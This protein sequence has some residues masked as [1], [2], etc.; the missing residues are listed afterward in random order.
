MALSHLDRSGRARMVDVTDKP[1]TA[2]IATASGKIYM[3]A[4]TLKQIH[5]GSVT[6]GDVFSVAQ[7]AGILAAKR[8]PDLIPMCHP[9]PISGVELHFKENS[10][11]NTE[12]VVTISVTAT[13][14]TV[15]QTGVEME[16]L[17][18]VCVAS[19]TLYDMCKS[20]DREIKL[21]DI[22]LVSKSGGR[23]GHYRRKR[24]GP[25]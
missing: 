1:Q 2:R 14:K 25:K 21:S 8:T 9:L 13:V 10:R 15:S 5:A 23:S 18:A 3:K 6:K 7:V 12:G 16:A 24:R 4:G 17:T 20:I 19:L 11:P 22:M